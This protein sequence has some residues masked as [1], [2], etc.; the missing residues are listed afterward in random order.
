M[1]RKENE[2]E[3]VD[4]SQAP[5]TTEA[6]LSLVASLTQQMLV[7]QQQAAEERRAAAE[8]NQ[9]LA[10]A[11]L[12]TTKPREI[13]KSKEQLARE[14]N[15]RIFEVQAKELSKRQKET[16]QYEQTICDHIA[17]GL[18]ETKDVHL[19]TSIVWHRTDAQVDVGICTTCG[20]QFHPDDPLDAQGHDYT[21]WRRK[22][23]FNRISAA[24]VRQ[25]MDPRKAMK[26][27]Y[28]RDN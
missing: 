15:D 18:G 2:T 3:A 21:Y 1:A 6:L 11:I 19:R 26:D 9:K 5:L 20:R 13:L 8:A 14:E 7:S 28:L 25:F 23:S 4:T 17:G 22:G 16:K 10:D 27:S 12:E 24:G